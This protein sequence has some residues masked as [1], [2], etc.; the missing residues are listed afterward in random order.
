M[1]RQKEPAAKLFF[2][3]LTESEQQFYIKWIYEAK[4][5]VTKTKR[6]VEA[7]GKLMKMK[8]FYEVDRKE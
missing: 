8:K 6:M 7:I 1:C 3:I 2:F 5:E 4:Q